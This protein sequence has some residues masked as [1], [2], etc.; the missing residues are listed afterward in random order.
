MAAA[1]V[2]A[3]FF[4]IFRGLVVGIGVVFAIRPCNEFLN[5]IRASEFWTFFIVRDLPNQKP[6]GWIKA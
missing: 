5:V 1:M 4:I 3:V 6:C 2:N